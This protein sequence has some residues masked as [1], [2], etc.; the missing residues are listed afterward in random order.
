MERVRNYF[1]IN[2][3]RK[4]IVEESETCGFR[5]GLDGLDLG[6]ARRT[7]ASALRIAA[8]AEEGEAREA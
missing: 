2:R 8:A 5:T 3:V 6:P 4:L 1:V 7:S